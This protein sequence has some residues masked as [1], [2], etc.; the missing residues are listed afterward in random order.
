M[1]Q[2]KEKRKAWMQGALCLSVAT[3]ILLALSSLRVGLPRQFFPFDSSCTH[4]RSSLPTTAAAAAAA[5]VLAIAAP[6]P[7]SGYQCT[8][9]IASHVYTHLCLCYLTTTS[10]SFL[11]LSLQSFVFFFYWVFFVSSFFSCFSFCCAALFLT[12]AQPVTH[13]HAPIR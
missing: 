6:F 12:L 7:R 3:S 8:C 11:W 10:S 1:E 2:E 5:A 13:A 9:L 4:T